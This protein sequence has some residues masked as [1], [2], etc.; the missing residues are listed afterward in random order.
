MNRLLR[1]LSSACR[2]L[3]QHYLREG[4][5]PRSWQQAGAGGWGE[6][7]TPLAGGA[8]PGGGRG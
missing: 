7:G 1:E 4:V 6:P 5:T 8:G 2:Q 3:Q